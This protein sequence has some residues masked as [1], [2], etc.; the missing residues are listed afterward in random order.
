[1]TL[2]EKL[3]TAAAK[4]R[5]KNGNSKKRK[6]KRVKARKAAATKKKA[7]RKRK[8]VKTVLQAVKERLANT[9]KTSPVKGRDGLTN[10][11]RIFVAEYLATPDLNATTAAR[12]SGYSEANA[13]NLAAQLMGNPSIRAAV[14]KG[15]QRRLERVEI[16]QER[17]LLEIAR[18]ALSDLRGLAS[19]S[20][21][22]VRLTPSEEISD[23]AA[24]CVSEVSESRNSKGVHV[25]FRLHSK[26]KALELLARHLQ[27]LVDRREN[28]GPGGGP[29][30]VE[31]PGLRKLMDSPESRALL[32]AA[33]EKSAE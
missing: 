25:K 29:M 27:M 23:A 24:A 20:T 16:T 31:V 5:K 9:P 15:M 21:G 17:V 11:Q 4:G 22:G 12:K 18:L 32:L 7:P 28:T 13:G 26:T 30:Q 2:E 8:T 1:M 10:Q 19:W 14:S 33:L 3:A 6:T